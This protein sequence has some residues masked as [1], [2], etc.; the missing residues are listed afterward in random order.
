MGSTA[1]Q[2]TDAEENPLAKL[3]AWQRFHVRLTGLYGGT[4]LLC[5]LLIGLIF[6]K[7][8]VDAEIQGLQQRLLAMVTSL[9]SSIDGERLTRIP[10]EATDPT[11]FHLAIRE[12]FAEVAKL[13]PDVESIYVLRPTREPT[14][15]R[16]LVDYVKTGEAGKPGEE[17]DATDIPVMI[18][19]FSAPA[20]EQEPYTDEFGTTLSGYAPIFDSAGK[21]IGIV[22]ADVQATR[23]QLLER[24]VRQVVLLVFGIAVLLVG[25]VSL[26]V[27]HSV[28]TPLT[29]IINAT[30]AVARGNYNTLIDLPRKD[31]FGLMGQHFNSM[32]AG[33]K[34]REFIRETFGRYVSPEVAN[35]VLNTDKMPQLGGEERVVSVLFSDLRG[36]STLA[37]R[38]PPVAVVEMMNQYLTEMHA[39]IDKYHGCVIEFMG[40]AI[41]AVFGAPYYQPDHSENALRC[42][43]EMRDHLVEL[44]EKW[45]HSGL[46]RY[47]KGK[48][49]D[50]WGA[51]I[52]IHTG[53]VVAGNVGS[54]TRFKYTVIGDTVNVAS[55]LETLNKELNT[56]ILL[57]DDV[58]AHLP[59]DLLLHIKSRGPHQVK[60]R[61]Q[62]VNVYSVEPLHG[63]KIIKFSK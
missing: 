27:A 31:E 19:G 4:V 28:R 3:R 59:E 60:G 34:D 7:S 37:E 47:W 35:A 57:S 45:S 17:Y 5:L 23:L 1:E 32:V 44:N 63:A 53:P 16:F 48:E 25:L 13:D 55:R 36:Y 29:R 24:Q 61:E 39:L 43:M 46:A 42:A 20:V 14:K 21:S 52:G 22:G 40:D 38:L 2:P 54:P 51:R 10:L 18:K 33:L 6:Y 41:L 49:L 56:D 9:A 11:A 50:R 62:S 26:A 8:G 30:A 15:L 12:R 58:Y